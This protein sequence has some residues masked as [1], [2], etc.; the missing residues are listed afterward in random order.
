MNFMS[1]IG[2]GSQGLSLLAPVSTSTSGSV[3]GSAVKASES[4]ESAGVSQGSVQSATEL[5]SSRLSSTAGVLAQSLSGPDERAGKVE[6]LQAA[7]AAGTYNVSAAD[8]ADK[9]IQSLLK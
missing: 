7:I 2:S 3:Q 5:S 8:V 9:L 6:A 4:L 1:G